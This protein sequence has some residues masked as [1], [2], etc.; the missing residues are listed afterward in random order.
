MK[1]LCV[2]PM[3]KDSGQRLEIMIIGTPA[4]LKYLATELRVI[5]QTCIDNKSG[6]LQKY[7]YPDEELGN[8][9]CILEITKIDKRIVDDLADSIA[10][11]GD[12]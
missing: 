4:G 3:V 12:D 8:H 2:Y 11:G 1:S 9:S 10:S 7:Y 5:A 6:K